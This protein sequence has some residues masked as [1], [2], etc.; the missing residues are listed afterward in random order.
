M[1]IFRSGRCT[2]HTPSKTQGLSLLCPCD[3]TTHYHYCPNGNQILEYTRIGQQRVGRSFHY[4]TDNRLTE[5]REGIIDPNTNAAQ[6]LVNAN[7][8]RG[9]GQRVTK[10]EA[11]RYTN[12]TYQGGT[13]LFTSD[14]NHNLINFHLNTPDGSLVSKIHYRNAGNPFSNLTTD[15]R[16][17]VHTVL[18]AQGNFST[19]FRYTDFGETTRLVDTYELHE[20]AY[21][22]GI[23]DESTG[24]YYLNARFYNPVDAVFLTM[25]IARNG[26]DLRATLSLYGYTEGD[27]INKIDPTGHFSIR[28]AI[29]NR[30]NAVAQRARA[31]ALAAQRAAALAARRAAQR[32]AQQRARLAAQRAAI[33]AAQR[34]AAAL[35]RQRAQAAAQR[36]AQRDAARRV[37]AQRARI[38]AQRV[39]Q[40]RAQRARIAAQQAARA[41]AQARARQLAAQ[42]ARQASVQP[43]PQ[44][45]RVQPVVNSRVQS[46]GVAQVSNQQQG[47]SDWIGP[48]MVIVG[49][50]GMVIGGVRSIATGA[51]MVKGG[52]ALTATGV[53][54]KAGLPIALVGVWQIVRGTTMIAGGAGAISYGVQELRGIEDSEINDR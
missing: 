9:D 39:A 34:R 7:T 46:A 35:V 50:A 52:S 28:A 40:Q 11:G 22:G 43:R 19:G 38:A 12:Y 48:T 26:G 31:A 13:V 6:N 45:A 23:W 32:A 36:A 37:A 4:N 3:T 14:D 1:Q 2:Q 21:T 17:S 30:V 44:Q 18:D 33:R 54:A 5:L 24:L 16:R 29:T 20:I 10:Y 41:A 15:I 8:F 27:P 49:G 51:K 53:G 25:D 47:N 42:R